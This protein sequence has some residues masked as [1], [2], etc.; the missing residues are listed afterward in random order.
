MD[1]RSVT[2]MKVMGNGSGLAME[3]VAGLQVDPEARP[4]DPHDCGS[5]GY[6]KP[7]CVIFY[8]G[9]RHGDEGVLRDLQSLFRG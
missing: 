3:G 7:A 4:P 9:I 2:A 8:V 6:Q 5:R 1:D